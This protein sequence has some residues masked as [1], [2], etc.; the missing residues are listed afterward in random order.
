MV[1]PL[2]TVDDELDIIDELDDIYGW[3]LLDCE[4]E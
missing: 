1:C 3:K 2:S 4:S